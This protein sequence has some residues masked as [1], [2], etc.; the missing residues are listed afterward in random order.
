MRDEDETKAKVGTSQSSAVRVCQTCLLQS[1][2]FSA[3]NQMGGRTKYG[4][5]YI[6]LDG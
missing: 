6:R 2:M 4:L 5:P 1:N 3:K